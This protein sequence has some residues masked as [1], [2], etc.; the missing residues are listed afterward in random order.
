MAHEMFSIK[1]DTVRINSSSLS[2]MQECSRK[3]DY[4]LNRGLISESSSAQDF[5]TLV[6]QALADWYLAKPSLRTKE[7]MVSAWTT[8]FTEMNYKPQDDRKTF[9]T[10]L[11]ALIK[12]ATLF[13]DDELEVMMIDGVPCV[14]YPFDV[15]LCGNIRL[16]GTID[17]IV[18]NKAGQVFVMDHKTTTTLGES[19]MN[20]WKP[21]HQMSAYVYAAQALGLNC[22]SALV[23]GIQ[24]VKTKQEVCRIE[25]HRSFE[26]LDDFRSTVANEVNRFQMNTQMGFHP[27]SSGYTC[28]GFGACQF[29]DY[30]KASKA[31]RE[32]MILIKQQEI[33]ALHDAKENPLSENQR[34]F[35]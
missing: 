9:D 17:L 6:H 11:A 25:T 27:A 12:Y 26:D 15:L 22:T 4:M 28:S 19:W 10:G 21:N 24:V 29:L 31:Q 8:R 32:M 33:K 34:C 20:L 3:A 1:G 5:G 23:Q 13:S 35:G 30:C 2:I 16:F 7:F 18:K 14:E